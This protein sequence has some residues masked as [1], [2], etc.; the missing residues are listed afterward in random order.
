MPD[1]PSLWYTIRRR[2]GLPLAALALLGVGVLL[3]AAGEWAWVTRAAPATP[4]PAVAATASGATTRFLR[5]GQRN[6]YGGCAYSAAMVARPALH[7]TP[8]IITE[9][10]LAADP[11]IC[12]EVVEQVTLAGTVRSVPVPPAAVYDTPSPMGTPCPAISSAA[13]PSRLA[14]A[15]ASMPQR[16][17]NAHRYIT[18]GVRLT[19]GQ[20]GYGGM[21]IPPDP[22][23]SHSSQAQV[24]LLIDPA[25]CQV[26]IEVETYR[27]PFTIPAPTGATPAA[28]ATPRP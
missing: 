5:Q 4:P 27:N 8:E 25:T 21:A 19:T 15:C 23:K 18:Q 22:G 10:P 6:V 13:T 14:Q 1:R 16:L 12:Q 26:L 11:T 2:L 28:A 20:C 17:G 24:T 3:G 9:R 7:A